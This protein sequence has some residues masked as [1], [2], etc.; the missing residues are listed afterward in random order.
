[1]LSYYKLAGNRRFK[2]LMGMSTGEFDLLFQRWRRRTRRRRGRGSPSGAEGAQFR[3]NLRNRVFLLLFY[4]RTSPPRTWRPRSSSARPRFALHRAGPPLVR[5]C[6]PIPA[7]IHVSTLE[8]LEE[9]LQVPSRR[10]RAADT[11]A[12][13]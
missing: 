5:Q 10:L 3:L 6:I 4:Y 7:K 11:E 12:Q 1:M 9:I 2:A 13:A 8:E